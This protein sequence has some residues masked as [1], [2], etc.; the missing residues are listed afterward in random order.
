MEWVETTGRTI[1]EAKDA[2]LDRL[3][4]DERDAEFDVVEEAR[5]GLFGRVRQEARV[6][7][8]VRPDQPR[9][10]VDRRDRRR[11]GAPPGAEAHESSASSPASAPA[12]SGT[13]GPRGRSK[14]PAPASSS[15]QDEDDGA[16]GPTA[17]E[18][19]EEARIFLDGLAEAFDVDGRAEVELLD[20]VT[21]EARLVG[22]D[23]GLLIGPK[24]QTL[25]AVQDLTRAAVQ[26][27]PRRGTRLRVD[28]GGYQQRRR[29]AL[30][31]FT[32]DVASQVQSGRS[33]VSMEP[34]PAIDRK[35][36]HDTVNTVDGV[37]SRSEG[38]DPRR[39]V[40]ILPDE[41]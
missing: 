37:I 1:A 32:L 16:P 24:G 34:M 27:G 6:R 28:I 19:A 38:E 10:R 21:V 36:V 40:V 22:D 39:W 11:R 2:A 30:A 18:M 7:A 13:S 35:V 23:L 33:P 26:H 31:R 29:E 9:P 14:A 41:S 4:V 25:A 8:R 20:H 15:R 3:G 5:S 12:G 17:L